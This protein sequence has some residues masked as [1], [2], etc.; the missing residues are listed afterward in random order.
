MPGSIIHFPKHERPPPPVARK[1][2][3]AEKKRADAIQEEAIR[4]SL[5]PE[6][7]KELNA[8]KKIGRFV[9]TR[10]RKRRG[11]T[12]RRHRKTRRHH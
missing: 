1:Q 5:S 2:T 12:R 10:H 9:V 11:G 3:A 7:L 6:E 4:E 8:R